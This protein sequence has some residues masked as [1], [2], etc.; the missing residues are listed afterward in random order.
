MTPLKPYLKSNSM[1]PATTGPGLRLISDDDI[2]PLW[3]FFMWSMVAHVA[4]VLLLL[5]AILIAQFLGIDI[6]LLRPPGLTPK[7]TEFVLVDN[8]PPEKPRHK[9]H[10]KAEHASRSGGEKVANQPTQMAQKAAGPA[11]KKSPSHPT[12]QPKATTKPSQQHPTPRPQPS[13][14][15]SPQ[16]TP[17]KAQQQP[18]QHPQPTPQ[19]PAPP[20]PRAP[21]PTPTATAP[22]APH[23]VAPTIRMP[24]APR[25]PSVSPAGPV[26]RMP[27][28][29]S[30]TSGSSSGGGGNPGPS[31]ISGAPSRNSGGSSGSP[32]A[33]GRPGS[34][35][36]GGGRGSYNQSGSPGGGGGRPGIDAEAEPD[37][38]P[39]IAELQRRI[40]RNWA[41]PTEDRN[42]RVVVIFHISRDGRL[43][44]VNLRGSSGSP[45]ADAAAIAAVKLS[46]PFRA[47]PPN[48]K[49]NDIPIEF[50][51]DYQ[52]FGGGA[53]GRIR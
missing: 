25:N 13:R 32:G 1:Q 6:P 2:S 21:R 22:S 7:D 28:S 51:F 26:A 20:A 50:T 44:S 49:G 45:S 9:T 34:A 19:P 29:T 33:Y 40:R 23:P 46:A 3:L 15:P 41:P 10:R 38:G 36:G 17:Q 11:S 14:Q 43:L 47:L 8:T 27:G 48:Y 30:S 39:Y 37:F 16:P 18:Q 24:S 52:V 53:G 12:A 4:V 5:L 42:K 35:G 31:M